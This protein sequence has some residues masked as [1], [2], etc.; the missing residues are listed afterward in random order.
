M[1]EKVWRE[2]GREGGR[3]GRLRT[4]R[5]GG[6]GHTTRSMTAVRAVMKNSRESCVCLERKKKRDM[7][8]DG[9][10]EGRRE[11]RREGRD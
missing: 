11:G 10:V 1:E 4:K 6:R 7:S 9:G 3:E 8:V 2:G 5:E